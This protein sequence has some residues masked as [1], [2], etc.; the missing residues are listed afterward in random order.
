MLL[1]AGRLPV[2]RIYTHCG[3]GCC[4]YDVRYLS[5]L[6]TVGL[7]GNTSTL[8]AKQTRVR[9]DL[10]MR[11]HFFI[12]TYHLHNKHFTVQTVYSIPNPKPIFFLHKKTSFSPFV[13][14]IRRPKCPHKVKDKWHDYYID[15]VIWVGFNTNQ[16]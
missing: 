8:K 11:F 4:D 14:P 5:G 3:E 13:R 6:R 12:G 7:V 10:Q 9:T 1:K 2:L 16:H 15:G